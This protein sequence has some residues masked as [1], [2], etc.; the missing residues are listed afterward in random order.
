MQ[1]AV[2]FQ[3]HMELSFSMIDHSL[4]HKS[5]LSKFKKMEII[6]S[7]FSDHSAMRLDINDR[8]RS[9]KNTRRISNTFLNNKDVTEEIRR[10][11]K[12]FI[13][14]ND[15]ENTMTQN[16]WDAAKQS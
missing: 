13:E 16:L 14:R 1:N 15:K 12:R 8:E 7:I 3:V 4:G 10:E 9:V 11:I 2:S 6:P 5:C